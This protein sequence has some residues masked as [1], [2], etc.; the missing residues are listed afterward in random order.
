VN[1]RSILRILSWLLLGL[2]IG[3]SIGLFLGW[4]AWPLELSEVDPATMDESFQVDYTLMIA[5][6]YSGDNDLSVARSRL[7]TL[8]KEDLGLWVLGVTVDHILNSEAEAEIVRLVNLSNDLGHY[9]PIM[10]PY[11]PLLEPEGT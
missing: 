5:S 7:N 10:E 1:R 2:I 3:A 8:G 11:L 9:S 4:V 6:S